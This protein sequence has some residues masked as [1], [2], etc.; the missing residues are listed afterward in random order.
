MNRLLVKL[1]AKSL[2]DARRIR[3]GLIGFSPNIYT[4]NA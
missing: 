1:L 4:K 2:Y 3:E